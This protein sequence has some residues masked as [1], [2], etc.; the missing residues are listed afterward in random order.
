MPPPTPPEFAPYL[1]NNRPHPDAI[2][3]RY[4]LDRDALILV[5]PANY[6]RMTGRTPSGTVASYLVGRQQF[7]D[8]F[9]TGGHD[10]FRFLEYKSVYRLTFDRSHTHIR[11]IVEVPIFLGC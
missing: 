7:L 8:S 3:V 6:H 9:N 2:C 1:R 4:W 11:R 5:G 10:W